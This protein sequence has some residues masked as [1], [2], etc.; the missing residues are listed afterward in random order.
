[1]S[2]SFRGELINFHTIDTITHNNIKYW[3]AGAII[4]NY[5]ATACKPSDFVS[6]GKFGNKLAASEYELGIGNSKQSQT[7][8]DLPLVVYS[9]L[10]HLKNSEDQTR[11]LL[12]IINT[13][14]NQQNQPI[15]GNS[16]NQEQS[17]T[18]DYDH[19]NNL[20]NSGDEFFNMQLLGNGCGDFLDEDER[21]DFESNEEQNVRYEFIEEHSLSDLEK[22]LQPTQCQN[23]NSVCNSQETRVLSS[24]TIIIQNNYQPNYSPIQQYPPNLP[25]SQ[26][27]IIQPQSTTIPNQSNNYS[28]QPMMQQFYEIPLQQQPYENLKRDFQKTVL[29]NKEKEVL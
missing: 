17:N 7:F 21:F 18:S 11:I 29:L 4:E 2:T 24:N 20:L 23:E 8:I 1:M 22:E 16:L 15:Q 9:L 12:H 25:N 28:Q 13:F 3:K 10:S 6:K 5:L 14:N 26:S 19:L 27:L